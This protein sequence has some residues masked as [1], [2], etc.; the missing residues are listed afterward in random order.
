MQIE[1][2]NCPNCGAAVSS[3][4]TLCEFCGSRL[5]TVACPKCFGMMFMGSKFCGHC[6]AKAVAPEIITDEKAGSCPRCKIHLGLLEI[7]G[8]ILREC[9]KCGGLWADV[10]TFENICADNEKQASVL[11]FLG[12]NKRLSEAPV[13]VNYV[14]CPDCGQLMNRSNF[15]RSSGVIIDLCKQHGAWFDADELPKIIEFIRKGGMGHARQKELNEIMEE[16]AR[17]RDAMGESALNG[18]GLDIARILDRNEGSAIRNFI[19]TL[20]D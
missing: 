6:G 13:K 8:T 20:F 18:H 19:K 17:L 4:K 15:A 11:G 16:R 3:D 14:P 1:T 12:A 5:K 10:E 9:E 2:L 7:G